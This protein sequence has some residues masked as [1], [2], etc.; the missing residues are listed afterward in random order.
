MFMYRDIVYNPETENPASAELIIGKQRN[1]PTGTVP[2]QFIRELTKFE[3]AGGGQ[4]SQ[5]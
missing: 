2:L 1:G 3:S 4:D 5:Y